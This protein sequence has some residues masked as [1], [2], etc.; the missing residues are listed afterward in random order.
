MLRQ[1]RARWLAG[2]TAAAVVVASAAFAALRNLGGDTAAKPAPPGA[3]A[4]PT[5]AQAAG[6]AAFERLK[7]M[8]CHSVAGQ[9]NP[10][11]PLDGVGAR[12][13][14]AALQEWTLGTGRAAGQLSAGAKRQKAVAVG[15]AEL[16]A[17]LDYL[18]SL[19]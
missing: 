4:A 3:A 11:N 5:A 7:C 1:T 10:A 2:A 8:N 17:L 18:A 15:D 9:G 13:D 12:L 14:R 16:P 19:K 6:R